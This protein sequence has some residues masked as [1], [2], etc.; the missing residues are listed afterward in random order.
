MLVKVSVLE[1][2]FMFKSSAL[3]D[4]RECIYVCPSSFLHPKIMHALHFPSRAKKERERAMANN[5]VLIQTRIQSA[6][7]TYSGGLY[8][9]QSATVLI[10]LDGPCNS[11][12][13]MEIKPGES[14]NIKHPP[15]DLQVVVQFCSLNSSTFMTPN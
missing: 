3:S 10:Y 2:M 1:S 9:L 7:S 6:H 11:C 15:F 5:C 8:Q 12:R 4:R 13:L 14:W